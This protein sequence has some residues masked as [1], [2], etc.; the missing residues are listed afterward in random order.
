MQAFSC[1]FCEIFKNIYS[2]EQLRATASVKRIY[3]EWKISAKKSPAY[4]KLVLRAG[5]L[6]LFFKNSYF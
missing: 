5:F 2:E 4:F 6:N 1:E 3:R